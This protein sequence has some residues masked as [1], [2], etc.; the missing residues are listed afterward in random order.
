MKNGQQLWK[1]VF[2]TIRA[3]KMKVHV[4]KHN[5]DSQTLIKNELELKHKIKTMD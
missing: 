5:H 2:M 4:Y 3:P 1:K